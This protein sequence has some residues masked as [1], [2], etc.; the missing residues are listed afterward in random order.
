LQLHRIIF[1][2]SEFGHWPAIIMRQYKQTVA[3][4]LSVSV[5]QDFFGMIDERREYLRESPPMLNELNDI[6][7]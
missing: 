1:H 4:P 6:Q 5:G 2:T 7:E 3:L